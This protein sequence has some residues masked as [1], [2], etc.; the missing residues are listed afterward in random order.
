MKRRDFLNVAPF[1]AGSLVA[2]GIDADFAAV[3]AYA[4]AP[5]A[6]EKSK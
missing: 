1:A 5:F 2:T 6:D 3:P 4:Q